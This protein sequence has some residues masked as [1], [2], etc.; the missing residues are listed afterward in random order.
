[1]LKR[2]AGDAADRGCRDRPRLSGAPVAMPSTR[3]RPRLDALRCADPGLEAAGVEALEASLHAARERALATL[4]ER[5]GAAMLDLYGVGQRLEAWTVQASST[6]WGARRGMALAALDAFHAR[7]LAL[8]RRLDGGAGSKRA[9]R[10]A[11]AWTEYVRYR[12]LRD[13][14]DTL[15][16]LWRDMAVLALLP[17]RWLPREWLAVPVRAALA[18]SGGVARAQVQMDL[19]LPAPGGVDWIARQ[20][21][22]AWRELSGRLEAGEPR[23]IVLWTRSLDPLS[24]LHAIAWRGRELPDAVLELWILDPRDPRNERRVRLEL[25]PREQATLETTRFVAFACERYEPASPPDL[26][27]DRTLASLGLRRIAWNVVR[28]FRLLLLWLGG[29]RPKD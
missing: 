4:C 18:A 5:F 16:H 10:R 8:P 24:A 2:S 3:L 14:E 1:M 6:D 7:R 22:E 27:W 13:L 21:A 19:A 28:A 12:S 9:R 26:G 15:E 17:R 25:E 29:G 20:N 23:P 11:Q